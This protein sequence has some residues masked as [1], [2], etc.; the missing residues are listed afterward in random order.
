MLKVRVLY[1]TTMDLFFYT[2]LLRCQS[3]PTGV[4]G[5]GEATNTQKNLAVC[6]FVCRIPLREVMITSQSRQKPMKP[7]LK[8]KPKPLDYDMTT[9]M[10]DSSFKTLVVRLIRN[11]NIFKLLGKHAKKKLKPCYLYSSGYL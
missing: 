9:G 10:M 1:V 3:S 11:V 4:L 6:D 5:F 2:W 8:S 7:K